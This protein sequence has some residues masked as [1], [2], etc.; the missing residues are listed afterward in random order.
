MSLSIDA[1]RG[2]GHGPAALAAPPAADGTAG[3]GCSCLAGKRRGERGLPRPP[4]RVQCGRWRTGGRLLLDIASVGSAKRTA[5][6][7][8]ERSATAASQTKLP[9]KPASFSNA[10]FY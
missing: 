5:L 8:F 7:F 10:V 4:T 2:S 1:T 6:A 9:T 3:S